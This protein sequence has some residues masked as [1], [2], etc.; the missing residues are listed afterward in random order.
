MT[1]C[2]LV[3]RVLRDIRRRDVVWSYLSD[4]VCV[5]NFTT[6]IFTVVNL[7]LTGVSQSNP[8]RVPDYRVLQ[9]DKIQG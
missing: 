1:W 4:W 7:M 6:Q 5:T 3:N 8:C 2:G 9:P